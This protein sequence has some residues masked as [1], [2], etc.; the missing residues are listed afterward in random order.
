MKVL[1]TGGT[2][3]IGSA[4]TKALQKRNYDISYLTRSPKKSSQSVTAFKTIPA[5]SNFDIIINLAGHPIADSRWTKS[6]KD[7]IVISRLSTTQ[8][9]I[10]HI[11]SQTVKPKVFISGSAIGIY[12]IAR[13]DNEISEFESRDSSFSSSLCYQW[14]TLAKQA[15]EMNIRTCLLRTGIVLGQNNG[16]LKK[17][18]PP[19]KIGLGG[20]IGDGKQ[21]MPWIH[22]DDMINAILFCIDNENINGAVNLT[23]PSPATN[24]E[25]T[26]IFSKTLKRPALLPMPAWLVKLLMGEMGKELLLSG[27]RVV[28]RK[29]LRA[30][31]QFRYNELK[32]ALQSIL[33][34]N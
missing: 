21:W 11:E 30:G 15:T 14:E 31:Y 29:L 24:N 5:D 9:I 33:K 22:I 8:K 19:F 34:S 2:G 3:F 23:A 17:M 28:P 25:F 18:L 13:D 4:L 10:N 6:T 12:G 1:L 26:Q 16:A 7:K 27:K 20:K 32:P